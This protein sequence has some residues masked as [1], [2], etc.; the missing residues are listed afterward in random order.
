MMSDFTLDTS[1]E[2]AC[3]EHG[4]AH[5]W[6][7]LTPFQQG[8]VEAALRPREGLYYPLTSR[9]AGFSD[10][11][12]ETLA[13]MLK[14]CEAWQ[15]ELRLASP[16]TAASGAGFWEDRRRGLWRHFPPLTLYLGD[17]GKVL[18][19]PEGRTA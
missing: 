4:W 6:S 18:Q 17:D 9:F 16:A 12:P 19:S 10:L 15:R 13:A 2:V 8:Y 14:D 3:D 1:G 7:D 11:A 5:V